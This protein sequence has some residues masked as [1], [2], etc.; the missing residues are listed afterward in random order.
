MESASRQQQGAC[1]L[2]GSFWEARAP[3]NRACCTVCIEAGIGFWS[4]R[5]SFLFSR[6]CVQRVHAAMGD[7]EEERVGT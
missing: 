3:A 6:T 1:Q 4:H 7:G 2:V 5:P